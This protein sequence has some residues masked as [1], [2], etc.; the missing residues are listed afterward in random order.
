MISITRSFTWDA[1]HRLLGHESRCRY[2]HG[3]RYVAEVSVTSPDLDSL[4]RVI[5]FSCLK[6]IIGKWI[7]ENWDHNILLHEDDPLYDLWCRD[8]KETQTLLFQERSPYCMGFANPT[9]ENIVTE[10]YRQI[11]DRLPEEIKI[12]HIRLWETEK[13]FCDFYPGF[14]PS[15]TR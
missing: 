2:L 6:E 13:C 10:L 5:D 9:A 8:N 11:K 1:A 7:D 12:I 14:I 3:H 15:P 4:G